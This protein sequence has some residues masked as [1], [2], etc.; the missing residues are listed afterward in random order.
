MPLSDPHDREHLHTR[1][2][3]FRGFRRSDGLWDIEGHLTDRK[4]YHFMNEFRG[5]IAAGEPLHDM[6]IRLT[7]DD[8]FVVRDIEAATDAGPFRVCPDIVPSFKKV[9]GLRMGR[10]WRQQ[11]KE[12]VGG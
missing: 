11:L 6:W 10:G 9:V 1:A 4:T 8:D 3:E 5:K 2:Y 7:I 12:R